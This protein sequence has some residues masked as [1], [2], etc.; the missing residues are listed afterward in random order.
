MQGMGSVCVSEKSRLPFRNGDKAFGK[1]GG[2]TG[3]PDT[4]S[5]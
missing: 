2:G 4:A 3:S 1:S 5:S